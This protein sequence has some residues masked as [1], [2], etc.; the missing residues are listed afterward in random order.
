[1]Q[2][3]RKRISLALCMVFLFI[4]FAS[5]FYIVEEADHHCT[6]EDC[7]VCAQI[8]E[9][10]QN[11]RNLGTG[12]VVYEST[13]VLPFLILL[14]IAAKAAFIPCTS[15]VEQKVRLNN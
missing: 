8:R 9:A 12:A 15:L 10:E 1:M 13:Y 6:G 2:K 7:P 3:S 11:L 14:V 4:T 5:L